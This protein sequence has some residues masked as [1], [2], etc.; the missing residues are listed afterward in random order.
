MKNLILI[1]F[2]FMSMGI[3]AGTGEYLVQEIVNGTDGVIIEEIEEGTDDGDLIVRTFVEVPGYYDFELFRIS[4]SNVVKSY[5]DVTILESWR[6][7]AE[8]VNLYKTILHF[9]AD[10]PKSRIML[11]VYDPETRIASLH[12][13]KE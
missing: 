2:L 9:P 3:R 12:Y 13:Y 4:I 11:I 6:R 5:S 1:S 8:N 10:K 7:D